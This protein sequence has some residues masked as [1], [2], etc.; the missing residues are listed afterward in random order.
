MII[1]GSNLIVYKGQTA[2]AGATTCDIEVNAETI[3]TASPT[4]GSWREFV[5][6]RKEWTISVSYLV[7]NTRDDLLSVGD[8][9]VL[10]VGDRTGTELQ[11]HAIVERVHITGN[12]G[13]IV[14]GQFVFRGNGELE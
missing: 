5:T 6:G 14:K 13:D 10:A 11:G 2:I 4:S 9:V 8:N 12:V 3:E 7:A 1:L